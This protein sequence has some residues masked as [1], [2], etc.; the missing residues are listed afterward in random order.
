MRVITVA[1]KPLSEGT[2][3]GNVL[4]HGCGALNIDASRIRPLAGEG[5]VGPGSLSDPS[6]R[7]GTVGGDLGITGTSLSKFQQA[8]A[9]SIARTNT[10]GRWPANLILMHREGCRQEGTREVKTGTAVQKNRDASVSNSWLGT[11]A[12]LVAPDA[13]YADSG[14]GTETI[15]SWQCTPDCPVRELD[16][17]SK[18]TTSSGGRIGNKDGGPWAAG[19][20]GFGDTGA[21]SRYFKHVSQKP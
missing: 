16:A 11:R 10:L 5:T 1:R 13:S 7:R 19:E 14:E 20:S 21:V 12:P 4:K 9:E 3:A 15:P 8:Q 6:Q 2:V 18:V 17:G